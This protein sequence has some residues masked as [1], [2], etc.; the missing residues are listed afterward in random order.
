MVKK[1]VCL[2]SSSPPR[3]LLTLLPVD[4][5]HSLPGDPIP[6]LPVGVKGKGQEIN[7]TANVMVGEKA[8]RVLGVRYYEFEE[9][10]RDMYESLKTKF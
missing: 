9:T 6:N 3:S 7:R 5:L 1:S 4:I 8:K 10:V 2:P